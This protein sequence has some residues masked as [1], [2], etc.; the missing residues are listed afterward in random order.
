MPPQGENLCVTGTLFL[1]GRPSLTVAGTACDTWRTS[2]CDGIGAGKRG[3]GGGSNLSQRG[4]RLPLGMA[5]GKSSWVDV[6]ICIG[7]ETNID[8]FGDGRTD[9]LNLGP[10][11]VAKEAFMCNEKWSTYGVKGTESGSEEVSG[12]RS[13]EIGGCTDDRSEEMGDCTNLEDKNVGGCNDADTDEVM[14]W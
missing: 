1:F 10:S 12:G 5:G 11:G 7:I 8:V 9:V 2:V 6:S 4:P 14:G 13:E 3:G